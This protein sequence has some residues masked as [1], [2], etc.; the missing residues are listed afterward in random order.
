MFSVIMI[1]VSQCDNIEYYANV[2]KALNYKNNYLVN[3][4][5]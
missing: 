3:I 2:R 4:L 5:N 1:Y